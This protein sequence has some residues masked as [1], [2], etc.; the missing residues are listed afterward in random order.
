MD[1]YHIKGSHNSDL[2]SIFSRFLTMTY[3]IQKP[4]ISGIRPSSTY[5]FRIAD[6]GQSPETQGFCYSSFNMLR[7]N[8]SISQK[9]VK[10]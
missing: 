5:L 2:S 8:A 10:V 9:S 1:A 3:G 4:W 6:D 7:K